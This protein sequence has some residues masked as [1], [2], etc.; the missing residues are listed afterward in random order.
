ME[1]RAEVGKDLCPRLGSLESGEDK[2]CAGESAGVCL[3]RNSASGNHGRRG[4][5]ADKL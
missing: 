1:M 2:I 5:E 4:S 3:S